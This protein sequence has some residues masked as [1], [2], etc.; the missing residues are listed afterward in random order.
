MSPFL[1]KIF[2]F[3]YAEPEVFSLDSPIDFCEKNEGNKSITVT[4]PSRI[5]HISLGSPRVGVVFMLRSVD[6]YV[7]LRACNKAVLKS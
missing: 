5:L 3:S 6:I 7:L 1:E 2:R 4:A